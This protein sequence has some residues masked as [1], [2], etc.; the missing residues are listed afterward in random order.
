L[1]QG[2]ADLR[3]NGNVDLIGFR[4][5]GLQVWPGNGDL[6]YDVA[7]IT[8]PTP[9]GVSFAGFLTADLDGDGL[10]EIICGGGILWN[11]GNFQFE[12]VA[13]EYN[14]VYGIADLNNDGRPDL[15]TQRGT[16]LNRGQGQF[17]QITPNGLAFSAGS[18]LAI[19]DF[20]GDGVLDAAT[21]EI[22]S[23]AVFVYKGQGDGTFVQQD[24]LGIFPDGS[25]YIDGIVTG[26]FIGAGGS[27]LLAWS[28][29]GGALVLFT[30]LPAQQEFAVSFFAPGTKGVA[31]ISVAD[32]NGDGMADVAVE[33]PQSLGVP[34]FLV[35]LFG[36]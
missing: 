24:V 13:L 14:G 34:P 10:P 4:G 18:E 2:F 7:A 36:Q 1:A 33:D 6:N 30:Y 23:A 35:V 3:G 12:F 22:A 15:I 26:D 19:G 25:G 16:F 8:I 9:A 28:S 21:L 11:M 32:F 20:D 27:Q 17:T 31:G 5:L 29:A